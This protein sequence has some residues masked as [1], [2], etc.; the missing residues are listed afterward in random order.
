VEDRE[1]VTPDEA[2]F[3]E[4]YERA[5]PL[6]FRVA[7][8]FSG[9][10]EQAEDATQEAFARAFARWPRLRGKPWI[11]G[12]IVTTTLN[13]QR[14]AGRRQVEVAREAPE[15]SSPD[16][17]VDEAL[18]LWRAL[19]QLPGRQAQAAVLHYIVDLPLAEVAEVMGCREGTA[20]A[21]LDRARRRLARLLEPSEAS[22]QDG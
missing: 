4:M 7:Y 5:F 14:R 18:D 9:R 16:E 12:W 3:R 19:G 21:H 10:R 15:R 13:V 22:R 1:R 6:V 11:V 20:K 8:R 2:D 17:D